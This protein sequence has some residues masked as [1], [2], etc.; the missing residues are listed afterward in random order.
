MKEQDTWMGSAGALCSCNKRMG[1]GLRSEKTLD[2]IL[3]VTG[4]GKASRRAEKGKRT[5]RSKPGE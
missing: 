3:R 2:L 1:V 4:M 5:V